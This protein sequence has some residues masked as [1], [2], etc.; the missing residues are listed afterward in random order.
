MRQT[1]AVRITPEGARYAEEIRRALDLMRGATDRVRRAG[2]NA[3]A[4]ATTPAFASKWLVPRLVHFQRHCPEVEVRLLTSNNLVD[5][6]RQDVDLAIRYGNGEWPGLVAEALMA[7]E[8]FPVCSPS[9]LAEHDPLREP[10]DLAAHRLLHLYH[11][12]WPDWFSLAGLKPVAAGGAFFSDAGLL[13]QAAI[14]G[15][16]VALGQSVLVAGDVAGGRLLRLFNIGLPAAHCYYL[17]SPRQGGL[18]PAAQSFR[19]WLLGTVA[20]A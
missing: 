2:R 14:E 5:F 4:I 19:D 15:Q 11:D 17:V 3:V 13:T 20:D 1:R 10:A 7:S 16:G 12:E 8:L 6:S 9:Y 18:E